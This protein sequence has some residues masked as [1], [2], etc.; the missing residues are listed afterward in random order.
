MGDRPSTE[1]DSHPSDPHP[2]TG[3]GVLRI[4][5]IVAGERGH[6]ML[7]SRALAVT[8]L[9]QQQDRRLGIKKEL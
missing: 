3:D 5:P 4:G 2:P 6:A 7:M 1:E 9:L 8:H